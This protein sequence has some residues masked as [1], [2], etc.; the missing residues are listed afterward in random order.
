M[1]SSTVSQFDTVKSASMKP[2]K[3]RQ[4]A[5][6]NAFCAGV[7]STA[8]HCSV[9]RSVPHA[10]WALRSLSLIS[11]E[12]CPQTPFPPHHNRVNSLTW[13]QREAFDEV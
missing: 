10:H 7:F 6:Q 13:I 9:R 2:Q 11:A 5:W 12:C 8:N 3:L 4:H 1:A